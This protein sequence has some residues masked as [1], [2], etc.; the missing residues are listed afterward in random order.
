MSLKTAIANFD[1]R[2]LEPVE[3]WGQTLYIGVMDDDAFT[4]WLQFDDRMETGKCRAIL[5][6]HT[7]CDKEGNRVYTNEDIPA[8]RRKS[9]RTID[10]LFLIARDKNDL[11]PAAIEDAKKN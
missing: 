6:A 7:I 3:A 1:D 9:H 4:S 8:L 2:Q 10:K 5:L 11:T